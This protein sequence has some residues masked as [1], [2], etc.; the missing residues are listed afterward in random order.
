MTTKYKPEV[1]KSDGKWDKDTGKLCE[2]HKNPQHN[3]DEC[4]FKESLLP[5]M[6]LCDSNS[7]LDSNLE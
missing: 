7:G 6:K 1:K 3:I 5:N 4:I 2:F